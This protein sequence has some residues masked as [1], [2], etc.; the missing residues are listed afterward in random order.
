MHGQIWKTLGDLK[1]CCQLPLC[2][3]KG[4]PHWHYGYRCFLVGRFV[5][6]CHISVQ[7]FC[8]IYIHYMVVMP[9]RMPKWLLKHLKRS[10]VIM[11]NVDI[12]TVH[13]R[14]WKLYSICFLIYYLTNCECSSHFEVSSR[15]YASSLV[16]V[17][18]FVYVFVIVHLYIAQCH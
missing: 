6:V 10:S 7:L 2:G 3:I 15:R 14:C 12:R 18:K 1:L 5:C 17:F 9:L 4:E 16:S 11:W 8:P 13:H